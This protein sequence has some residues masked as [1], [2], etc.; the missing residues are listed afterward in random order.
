MAKVENYKSVAQVSQSV[1]A[2]KE[3]RNTKFIFARVLEHAFETLT[4]TLGNVRFV[5]VG[6]NDGVRGDPLTQFIKCG[7]WLGALI[8]PVPAAFDRLKTTYTG[9]DGL[10]LLPLAIWPDKN[11]PPFYQVNGEDVLSSFSLETIMRHD[12]KYDDLASMVRKIPVETR[13]LDK[14]CD[15]LG[16]P[17]PDVLVVDVE[18]YD[19]VILS[20]FDIEK[21]RPAAIMF[22]H[23]ALSRDASRA[24][25]E[26]LEQC[27]Y[28]LIFDR[29]DCLCLQS[30]PFDASL[31]SFYSD[32]LVIARDH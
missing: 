27:G 8:E 24:L 2:A 20:S 10:T 13:R 16:M 3:P 5:Q 6:A 4:K 1:F 11:P 21:H 22:E 14:V 17:C 31:V 28:T 19:D 9:V 25:R 12:G 29:H 18:G 26:R 30:P 15:D 32:L 23:V 7:N